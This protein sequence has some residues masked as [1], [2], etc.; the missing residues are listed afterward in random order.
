MRLFFH[1][2]LKPSN[3]LV[4]SDGVLKISEFWLARL[5]DADSPPFGPRAINGAV[6]YPEERR[7]PN[8]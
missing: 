6:R 7:S 5:L 4:T 1:S 2:D 8:W 3:I